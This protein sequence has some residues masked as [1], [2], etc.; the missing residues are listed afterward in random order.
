MKQ[1][2]IITFIVFA[3]GL[4]LILIT[5]VPIRI[6]VKIDPIINR[7]G[8]LLFFSTLIYSLKLL[9]TKDQK[10]QKIISSKMTPFYKFHI[11][12]IILTCLLFVLLLVFFD[13]YPGN[14]IG[15]FISI[16]FM[17]FIWLLLFLPYYKL[18][19]VYV[20]NNKIVIDD[21]FTQTVLKLER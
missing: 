6:T 20:Q 14:E 9:S 12:V 10:K 4:F 15:V 13:L 16:A 21:F 18:Q 19:K 7:F 1:K 5:N 11:P 8:L 17:L 2:I 3:I